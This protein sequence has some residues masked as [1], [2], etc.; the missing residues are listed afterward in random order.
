MSDNVVTLGFSDAIKEQRRKTIGASEAPALFGL[1]P[2]LSAFELGLDKSGTLPLKDISDNEYVQAG[3]FMEEGI[4]RWAQHR[5]GWNLV[6]HGR[7]M[8]HPQ[9]AGW[10]ATPDYLREDLTTGPVEIK[11]VSIAGKEGWKVE[12]EDVGLEA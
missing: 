5:T 6:K 10:S 2:F 3:V 7:Y 12:E 11:R 4:A 8:V 9:C 1:H